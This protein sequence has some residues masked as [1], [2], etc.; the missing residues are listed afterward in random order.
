MSVKI[1]VPKKEEIEVHIEYVTAEELKAALRP[2]EEKY[3]LSSQEFYEKFQREEIPETLETIDWYI[4]YRAYLRAI[5]QLNDE[6]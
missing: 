3:G 1:K 2:Y 6:A 5:G 4:E